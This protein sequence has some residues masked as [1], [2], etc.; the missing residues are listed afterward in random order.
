MRTLVAPTFAELTLR[1]IG[2]ARCDS[3]LKRF[4]KQSSNRA[5]KARVVLRLALGLGVMNEVIPRN[6]TD[7]VSLLRRPAR[8]PDAFEDSDRLDPGSS[9]E[10]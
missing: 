1:E 8:V 6:P 3:F 10:R 2:V 7:H 4:A 9:V 5:R